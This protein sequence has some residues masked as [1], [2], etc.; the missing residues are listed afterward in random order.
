MPKKEVR[1]RREAVHAALADGRPM[2]LA[3]AIEMPDL[4]TIDE[5]ERNVSIAGAPGS[6]DIEWCA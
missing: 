2:T 5:A 1:R 3:R 4:V 6:R